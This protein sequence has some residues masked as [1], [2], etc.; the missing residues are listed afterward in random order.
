M[1]NESIGI[2]SDLEQTTGKAQQRRNRRGIVRRE[3]CRI[4]GRKFWKV[5]ITIKL[6]SVIFL[7]SVICCI[8]APDYAQTF[9]IT[10]SYGQVLPQAKV[11]YTSSSYCPPYGNGKCAYWLNRQAQEVR[12]EQ[13]A[14]GVYQCSSSNNSW[15]SQG[16]SAGTGAN[17]LITYG[18]ELTA[19]LK[20]KFQILGVDYAPPGAQSC[21]NYGNSSMQGSSTSNT[22]TWATSIVETVALTTGVNIPGIA[23]GTLSSTSANTYTQETDDTSSIAVGTTTSNADIVR[24]P[25]SSSAGVDHDYDIVWVWLNPLVDLLLNPESNMVLWTGYAFN[26]EDD[27]GQME[28]VPLYVRWLKNPATIPANVAARLARSWDSSGNGGLTTADYATI[29]AAD[30]FYSDS[31]NPNYDSHHRFD[32]QGSQA[33]NYEPPPGGGQPITETFSIAAQTTSEQGQSAQSTYISNYTVDSDVGI[34]T[35]AAIGSDTKISNTYTTTDKWSAAI[36]SVSGKTASLSITG[37]AVSDNY[38]GPT[39]IQ[40]WRDNVYG[41]FMFYPVQ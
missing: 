5:A 36:N 6:A 23:H 24:G 20:V 18:P 26:N 33:F 19:H 34:N 28:V 10:D 3:A 29:L 15:L 11:W 13:G 41:S 35:V 22:E 37:P 4:C 9:Q 7:T 16:Y 8:S 2:D 12:L 31:Y 14:A 21:V 38:T 27:A 30:P 1:R 40:V 25:A 17:C 32:L 39:T